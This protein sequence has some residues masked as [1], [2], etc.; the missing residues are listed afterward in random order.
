MLWSPDVKSQLIGKDPDDEED[1]L[2]KEKEAAEDEVFGGII[3][4]V[5]MNLNKLQEIM[6]DKG[7]WHA[8]VYG[9]AKSQ[10]RLSNWTT[11]TT[12]NIELI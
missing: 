10:T 1:W 12:T 8:A 4:S 7:A 6:K 5:E 11:I 9:V 3:D 2:Q